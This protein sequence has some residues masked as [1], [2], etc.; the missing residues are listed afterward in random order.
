MEQVRK[1][2]LYIAMSL[3]GYIADE[4]GGIG[5]LIE[6]EGD[7]GDNGYSEFIKTIDTIIMGKTTYEQ[8]LGFGEWLY[9][10][11]KCYVYSRKEKGNNDKVEFTDQ[12]PSDLIRS[13][14]AQKGGDIWLE[15]GSLS[16]DPFIKENLI[17]EFI[18]AIIPVILGKG[19]PLFLPD[20]P[21]IK[22]KLEKTVNLGEIVQLFYIPQK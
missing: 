9:K 5:W 14:K 16:A 12:K 3:D 8:V 7:G 17:D 22:L 19:I 20:N 2:V 11:K 6:Q 18:I 21:R 4:N 15:G 1:C 10:G 13:L